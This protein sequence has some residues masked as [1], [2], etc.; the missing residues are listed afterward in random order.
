[1]AAPH[2]TAF[3]PSGAIAIAVAGLNS[4]P[5]APCYAVQCMLLL[6]D[7]PRASP[8]PIRP[9]LSH[10]YSIPLPSAYR[11]LPIPTLRT[12]LPST[13]SNLL[14]RKRREQPAPK[15]NQHTSFQPRTPPFA[16]CQPISLF[17]S[18][19]HFSNSPSPSSTS[20]PSSSLLRR[21]ALTHLTKLGRGL[22][23][24]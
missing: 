16:H 3:S 20:K 8:S 12:H 23:R 10:L 9:D 15:I 18:P 24:V 19:P 7:G 1:M 2:H 11:T 17:S 5:P 14:L 22:L 4:T 21:A 6:P 13:G